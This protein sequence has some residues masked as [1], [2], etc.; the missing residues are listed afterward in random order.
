M[1]LDPQRAILTAAARAGGAAAAMTA[2]SAVATGA[3]AKRRVS[4]RRG[5]MTQRAMTDLTDIVSS[6][7]SLCRTSL[8]RRAAD[9]CAGRQYNRPTRKSNRV[10]VALSGMRR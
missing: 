4:A 8:L 6:Q 5:G 1:Q 10:V 3:T 2:M 9:G 7:I